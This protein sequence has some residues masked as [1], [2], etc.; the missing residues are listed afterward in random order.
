MEQIISSTLFGIISAVTL[1]GNTLVFIMF[2]KRRDWLNRTHP[3]LLQALAVQDIITG[4]SLILSPGFALPRDVYDLQPLSPKSRE[5]YCR[6][7]RSW[8]IPFALSIVSIYTCLMLAAER[9]LAV[10]KPTTY[11]RLCTSKALISAMVILPWL[12]GFA[13]EIQTAINVESSRNDQGTYVCKLILPKQSRETIT[14]ALLLFIVGNLL[15]ALLMAVC[16]GKLMHTLKRSASKLSGNIALRRHSNRGKIKSTLALKKM[17]QM[18]CAASVIAVI[19]WLPD[20]IYYCLYEMNLI[21]INDSI[22]NG[23][24]I[25]AFTNTCL[26]PILYNFSNRQYKNEFKVILSHF[27]NRNARFRSEFVPPRGAGNQEG[28]ESSFEE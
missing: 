27:F 17:T 20:Q 3:C 25:L 26:N 1:A 23:L 16:Y 9:C 7:I 19:F 10:W 14:A 2:I 22:H 5:W 4:L 18:I 12:G 8:Y 21:E 13:F 24:H 28:K 6:L 15:P 11:K